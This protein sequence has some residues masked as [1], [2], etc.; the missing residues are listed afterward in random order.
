MGEEKNTTVGVS[1]R[2]ACL[3]RTGA[4]KKI[5]ILFGMMMAGGIMMAAQSSARS[6]DGQED[7][8]T[9][10]PQVYT[11]IASKPFVHRPVLEHKCGICHIDSAGARVLEKAVLSGKT[12]KDIEWVAK[13]RGKSREHWL[14]LDRE[15]AGQA[16]MIRIETEDGKMQQT[17]EKVPELSRLA[18]LVD[19]Q[20][21][22]AIEPPEVV[23]VQRGVLLSATIVWK[24]SAISD[25]AVQYGENRLDNATPVDSRLTRQHEMVITGLAPLKTYRFVA[26]ST[27]V[28]GNTVRSPE[29]TFSTARSFAREEVPA[30]AKRSAGQGLE[31]EK[32]YHRV[33]D[34]VL[35]RVAASMPVSVLVG[36]MPQPEGAPATARRQAPTGVGN[37]LPANHPPMVDKA[38][39]SV[40][41]CFNCHPATKGILSHPVNVFPKGG[42]VI[43]DDY[44]TLADGRISCMSCHVPHA[45]QYQYRLPK[46]TKKALCIGCHRNFR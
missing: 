43:P 26:V 41:V 2:L 40:A 31:V 20:P 42:M 9:C 15:L 32:T 45:G 25:S 21:G 28:S 5:T 24:T 6:G 37:R 46:P 13:N 44:L 7:C 16:V 27:D 3:A 23:N 19:Q 18:E 34:R 22:L 35:L 4:G 33:K 11:E 14:T 38:T 12:P 30:Q 1:R 10:H 29:M 39:L 8:Q 36:A 17:T